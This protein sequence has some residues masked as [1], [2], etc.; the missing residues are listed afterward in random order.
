MGMSLGEKL[1]ELRKKKAMNQKELA[2]ASGITQG[3]ISRIEKGQVLQLKSDALKRLAGALGVTMD[4]LGDKTHS[5]TTDDIIKSDSIAQE[6]F[7]CYKRISSKEREHLRMFARFLAEQ[8]KNA[9]KQPL[10]WN[11]D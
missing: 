1:K 9:Y 5:L 4:Y 11:D 7:Q 2:K 3:T 8:T 10:R 6:I